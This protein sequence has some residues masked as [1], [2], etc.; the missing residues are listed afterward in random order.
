VLS[1]DPQVI[2]QAPRL[3]FPGVGAAQSA[4][5]SLKSLN[6]IQPLHNFLLTQ[7]PFLGICL[8]SQ[9]ILERSEENGGTPGLGFLPGQ[10]QAF[11]SLPENPLKIPQIGWNE[12]SPTTAH[13]VFEGVPAGAEFYFVHS[14]YPHP[15]DSR[16]ILAKT[17]Y[18][19]TSFASV[20]GNQNIIACQFHPEKSGRVGLKFLENFCRWDGIT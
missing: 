8:G 6:L 7:K 13:P 15:T 18:G 10:A 14:Y 11:K 4:M 5:D 17:I 3:V 12:V 20:I 16:H 1:K 2:S 9:I 19:R